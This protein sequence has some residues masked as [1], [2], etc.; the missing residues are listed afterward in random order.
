MT[1]QDIIKKQLTIIENNDELITNEEFF[2]ICEADLYRPPG[3]KWYS[4][5]RY[6][7]GPGAKIGAAAVTIATLGAYGLFRRL[8]N[9]CRQNCREITGLRK[10]RCIAVCNMNGSKRV[11]EKIKRD[12]P[13]LSKIKNR[14]KREKAEEVINVEQDKWESRYDKYKN[15]VSGLSSM[16]TQMQTTMKRKKK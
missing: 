13:K 3:E 12:R 1:F 10:Q 2:I 9:T 7:T 15:Q 16:V 4:K 8:T 11:V 6:L 14:E 5:H